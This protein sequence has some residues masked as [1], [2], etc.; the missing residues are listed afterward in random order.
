MTLSEAI[1]ALDAAG[2]KL[3][4]TESPVTPWQTT[5]RI[6]TARYGAPYARTQWNHW[7]TAVDFYMAPANP[8]FGTEPAIKT[9]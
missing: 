4:A 3:E 8:D 2:G 1:N 9:Q 7:Q 5:V 6:D